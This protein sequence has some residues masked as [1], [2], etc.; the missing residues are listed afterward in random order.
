MNNAYKCFEIYTVTIHLSAAQRKTKWNL[1][2]LPQDVILH[3]FKP[4]PKQSGLLYDC[5]PFNNIN[6]YIY[7]C[8]T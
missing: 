4:E 1:Y 8:N 3:G 5:T 6:A 7:M 2:G